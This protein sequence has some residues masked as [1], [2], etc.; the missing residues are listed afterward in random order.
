MEVVEMSD[1]WFTSDTHFNAQ[2]TLDLSKRPFND[3]NEMNSTLVNNWNNVVGKN[4]IVFHLGDFGDYR[5]RE[6]LN[7]EIILVKGNYERYYKEEFEKYKDYFKDYY[8]MT[9]S[10][11][12]PKTDSVY[13]LNMSHEPHI[14]KNFKLNEN[15]F[16][17]FGHVHK[18]CM[19]KPYGLNVGT[20]C[21]NF[22]PINLET[23]KYYH[24]GIMNYFDDDVFY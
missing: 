24:G 14:I 12:I 21:H 18:L 6:F 8:E 13:I 11:C 10:I 17:L 15:N 2:R 16:N 3:L 20:D 22:T 7:G 1:I 5:F 23:V 9:Y 4:D 19:I